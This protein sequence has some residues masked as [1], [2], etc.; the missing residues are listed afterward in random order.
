MAVDAPTESLRP[1]FGTQFKFH[2]VL[3]AEIE[4]INRRRA[5]DSR[6][7]IELEIETAE[8]QFGEPVLAPS[9]NANVVGLA[10]SGGG[11]RS[12]AFCLGALQTLETTGVL[13]R[14]DYVSTVSGGGYIGC[15]LTAALECSQTPGWPAD[16]FPFTSQ[17]KEDE[18][19]SL[20]HIR[21]HSNYLFPRGAIDLLHNASIYARGLAANAVLVAPFILGASA[22]TLLAHP[23]ANPANRHFV[24]TIG[25]ALFLIAAGIAWG[26]FQSTRARQQGLEIPGGLTR[27]VGALVII[28]FASAFCEA[29][30]FVLDTLAQNSPESLVNWALSKITKISALLAPVGAVI[31]FFASKMGEFIK[32]ATESAEV[33]VRIAGFVAK[34]A[35]YFA[36][37]IVPLLLWII[38]LNVTLYGL[39]GNPCRV[40]S[41]YGAAAFLFFILTLFMRPNANSLHPL[42][43]DRLGEAF[44][45]KPQMRLANKDLDRWRPLLSDIS[46]QHGPYHL[47]NAALNVQH[48]K[49]ANAT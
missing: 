35:I 14:V 13:K 12:A 28:L 7:P 24:V 6:D 19:P 21:D 49:T 34:V 37:T 1:E 40:A 31:A 26:I 2:E 10:L 22:L 23:A 47:V 25:L 17:F 38:Y 9:E 29:Q 46:L 45:F 36:G 48:S 42:Y 39:T 8:D 32:S 5:L 18:T 41:L 44:I 33:R 20:Q 16:K 27:W 4:L 43:R 11:V 3:K 30:P 15:S